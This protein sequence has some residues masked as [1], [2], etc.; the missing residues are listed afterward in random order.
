MGN[1]ITEGSYPLPPRPDWSTSTPV[2]LSLSKKEGP[3]GGDA[4]VLKATPLVSAIVAIS[5]HEKSTE[6]QLT[7]KD[8]E[9]VSNTVEALEQQPVAPF[10]DEKD[11]V[12]ETWEQFSVSGS[13]MP[14]RDKSRKLAGHGPKSA[15]CLARMSLPSPMCPTAV[16]GHIPPSATSSKPKWKLVGQYE[17]ADTGGMEKSSENL[18]H[19]ITSAPNH[20]SISTMSKHREGTK[21]SEGNRT[22]K[23]P[24]ELNRAPPNAPTEP[25]S[26]RKVRPLSGCRV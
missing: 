9:A 15:S 5:A 26:M 13:L 1:G 23:A 6:L 22:F 8:E 7:A 14:H 24:N 12:E 21:N 2:R 19:G 25:R 11:L 20:P 17:H 18:S 3:N 10:W 16:S 4:D